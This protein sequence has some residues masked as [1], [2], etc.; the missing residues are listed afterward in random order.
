MA[1]EESNQEEVI[2]IE[3][4]DKKTEKQENKTSEEEGN[5]K[6]LLLIAGGVVALLVII[7]IVVIALLLLE[8]KEKPKENFSQLSEKFTKTDIPKIK[9]SNIENM[10][11]KANYLYSSG[12]RKKALKLYSKIANYNESLSKYNLGVAQLSN[13]QYKIAFE[14]FKSAIKNGEHICVSAI[15]AAVCA[16]YLK[17]DANFHYYIDLAESYLPKEINSKLYSYYF[18]LI[19][20]YKEDYFQT[21]TSL[22]HRSS[23]E[24]S[25]E[26]NSLEAKVYTLFHNYSKAIDKLEANKNDDDVLSLAL[27]YANIGEL[28]IAQRYAKKA[29]LQGKN[30]LVSQ[31]ALAYIELKNKEIGSASEL[32]KKLD[33]KYGSKIY[34]TF[35]IHILLKESL[36][37]TKMA[38]KYYRKTLMNS[39]NINF[40]KIFYFSPYKAFNANRTISYIR[41]G[42]A[43]IYIDDIQSAKNYLKKSLKTSNVNYIIVDAIQKAISHKLRDANTIL[44]K[45]HKNFPKH[46][47][48]NY[49]LALT[50]AQLGDIEN[51]HTYFLQSYY[52]DASNYLSGIYAVMCEKILGINNPKLLGI[53]KQNLADEDDTEKIALY[54][55]LIHYLE[56]NFIGA[57]RWLNEDQS[58]RPLNLVLKTLI[59]QGI[60]HQQAA[61]LYAEKLT[62]HLPNDILTHL[63]YIDTHYNRSGDI[64]YVK[65][66]LNYLR[67]QTFSYQDLFYGANITRELYT[68]MGL[69]TGKMYDL[70]TLLENKL[71]SSLDENIDLIKSLALAYLYNKEFEKA[72]LLY[73]QLIDEYKIRDSRTL[74][75]GAVASIGAEHHAN[76]LALLELA[77][78]KNSKNYESRYALGL[79]YMET[80]NSNGASI[81]FANIGNGFKSHFF[82]F[83]IDTQKLLFEKN[84]I[85]SKKAIH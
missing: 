15:N 32:L 46:T 7:L 64:A 72:Y 83:E 39:Q 43:N 60:A 17:A 65:N 84:H 47:I 11:A 5:N 31:L 36:F 77:K 3:D 56:N 40:Q 74:F 67:K 19:K 55:T 82:E 48:L 79:L 29:I 81:Q 68:Q 27:L 1:E 76:A 20:Y 12:N 24:Y 14:S 21:L 25:Q 53:I 33:N 57:S 42:N 73:N 63:I 4:S 35:P 16:R 59:A 70:T 61:Q 13:K 69:I 22:K 75:L 34:D 62:Y 49:N 38:Q 10:I 85:K 80:R 23:D 30:P 26:Q 50:Y 18:T 45:A 37:D 54:R 44:L 66:A 8:K 41:K 78:I 71:D 58:E 6:K 51:A 9:P 2:I 52:Q 28:R